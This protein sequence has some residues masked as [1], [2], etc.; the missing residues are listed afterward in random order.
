MT[1]VIAKRGVVMIKLSS[2][3]VAAFF[4]L[5]LNNQANGDY[6]SFNDAYTNSSKFTVMNASVF[7]SKQDSF[8]YG[9]P[10]KKPSVIEGC[11][12]TNHGR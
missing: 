2:Q 11:Y 5:S 8:S 4:P 12:K 6:F 10:S 9:S 1:R 3:R 7:F